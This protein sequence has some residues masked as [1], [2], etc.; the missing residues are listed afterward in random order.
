MCSRDASHHHHHHGVVTPWKDLYFPK[1]CGGPGPGTGA[2]SGPGGVIGGP[3][4]GGYPGTPGTQAHSLI[5]KVPD[6]PH[7]QMSKSECHIFLQVFLFLEIKATLSN[8]LRLLARDP[9]MT[10]AV[11]YRPIT[12]EVQVRSQV[13]PY[14]ICVEQRGNVSGFPPRNLA[15]PG[16][17]HSTNDPFS[18]YISLTP[19]LYKL[20]NWQSSCV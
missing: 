15:F 5:A 19:K 13:A 14:G 3:G 4:P 20:I 8:F 1:G 17:Y 10:Q 12:A 9:L 11:C 18:Y 7:I 2:A 16:Q 6:F